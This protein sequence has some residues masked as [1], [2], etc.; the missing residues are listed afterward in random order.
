LAQFRFDLEF[1]IDGKE[2]PAAAIAPRRTA[3]GTIIVDWYST[4]DP[5]NPQNWSR[6]KRALVSLVVCVYTF[7]VYC[8]SS[9]WLSSEIGVME[10]WG[11]S[12]QEASLPLSLYVLACTHASLARPFA[13]NRSTD[14]LGPL[15]FA[16]LSEIPSIGRN[17]VYAVTFAIFV[18]ISV[19]AVLV[20]SFGGLLALRFLQG[21]FGSPCLANGGASMQDMYSELNQPYAMVFWV[22]GMLYAIFQASSF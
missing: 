18:I 22:S 11:I 13:A 15:L 19:P 21:F 20:K 16:P 8:G 10:E 1:A 2:K 3:G 12:M 17:P 5:A 9:I 7:A 14:G 4:D 6:A